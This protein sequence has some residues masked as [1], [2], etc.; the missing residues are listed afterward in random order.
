MSWGLQLLRK[1]HSSPSWSIWKFSSLWSSGRLKGWLSHYPEIKGW[2]LPVW[3]A[4]CYPLF[5]FSIWRGPGTEDQV[6]SSKMRTVSPLQK[7]MV[8]R[9]RS[10][11]SVTE[12]KSQVEAYGTYHWSKGETLCFGSYLTS[13]EWKKG[14]K[15]ISI[16]FV[17]PFCI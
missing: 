9:E 2:V 11:T 8:Q 14:I 12:K 10:K 17:Y 7:V 6:L 15:N 1:F 16:H 13:F 3:R 4:D 5:S